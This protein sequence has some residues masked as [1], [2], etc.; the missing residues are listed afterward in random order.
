M[1]G[2][3]IMQDFLNFVGQTN[4][5]LAQK[6]STSDPLQKAFTVLDAQRRRSYE[7]ESEFRQSGITPSQGERKSTTLT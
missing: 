2:P 1:Y 3:F 5:Q 6:I 4:P 7:L